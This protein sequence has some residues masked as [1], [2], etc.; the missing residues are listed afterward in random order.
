MLLRSSPAHSRSKCDTQITAKRT[1]RTVPIPARLPLCPRFSGRLSW[2]AS[3]PTTA[4][5][6][7]PP[8]RGQTDATLVRPSMNLS[9]IFRFIE[10][11]QI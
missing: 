1:K 11:L 8:G 4:R 5:P 2:R 3:A 10:V 9:A 7:V 6:I